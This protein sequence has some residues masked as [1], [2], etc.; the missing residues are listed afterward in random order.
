MTESHCKLSPNASVLA[1][2]NLPQP[3]PAPLHELLMLHHVPALPLNP[4][5]LSPNAGLLLS[6]TPSLK[7][8]MR[9]SDGS[10]SQQVTSGQQGL[11]VEV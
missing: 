1:R 11:S 4:L 6:N 5:I 10:G 2:S 8:E 9:S 7:L 3:G